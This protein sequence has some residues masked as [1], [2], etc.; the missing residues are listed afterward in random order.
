MKTADKIQVAYD[1]AQM[2][3]RDHAAYLEI[4]DDGDMLTVTKND[5]TPGGYTCEYEIWVHRSARRQV[6][7]VYVPRTGYEASISASD[8]DLVI[9]LDRDPETVVEQSRAINANA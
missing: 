3:G 7:R 4:E 8:A 2:I 6:A 5:P 9:M 1:V